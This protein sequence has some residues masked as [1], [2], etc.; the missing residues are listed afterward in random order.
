M[1]TQDQILEVFR[2]F[3]S[4]GTGLITNAQLTKVLQQLDPI[5]WD[6][7]AI[8]TL[9]VSSGL[10][11]K[12]G[13]EDAVRYEELIAWA[14]NGKTGGASAVKAEPVCQAAFDGDVDKLRGLAKAGDGQAAGQ[15]GYVQVSDAVAGLWTMGFNMFEL[16]SLASEPNL[17]PATPLQYAA[18]AGKADVIRYLIEECGL[19]KQEEGE[20]GASAADIA[21]SHRV[22]LD[23]EPVVDD[24]PLLELLEEDEAPLSADNLARTVTRSLQRGNTKKMA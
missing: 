9:L 15:P 10:S 14:M 12:V 8:A 4:K 18:F 16:R 21:K 24:G 13:G 3:D 7:A 11:H 2:N 6:D 22:G 20:L 17:L 19:S 1:V 5:R 23:G